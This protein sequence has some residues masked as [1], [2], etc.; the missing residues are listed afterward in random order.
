MVVR[1]CI[2]HHSSNNNGSFLSRWHPCWGWLIGR[3]NSNLT[4]PWRPSKIQLNLNFALFWLASKCRSPNLFALVLLNLQT[5]PV[6]ITESW[7]TS[8]S[9]LS[10]PWKDFRVLINIYWTTVYSRK[11]WKAR[12]RFRSWKEQHTVFLNVA[13]LNLYWATLFDRKIWKAARCFWN[14]VL[15][16]INWE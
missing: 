9:R 3:K 8:W 10:G 15:L 5:F 11:L 2:H 12:R 4:W 6:L 14:F 13:P 1:P 16:N 7:K